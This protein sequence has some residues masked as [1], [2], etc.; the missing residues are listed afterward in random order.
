MGYRHQSVVLPI[1]ESGLTGDKNQAMIGPGALLVANNITYEHNTIRKEGGAEI[2]G[3]VPAAT[4][5]TGGHDFWPTPLIQ[6]EVVYA[7]V[8]GTASLKADDGNGSFLH[9]LA[10]GLVKIRPLFVEGGAET[11]G[12]PKKLFIFGEGLPTQVLSGT[13]LTTTVIGGTPLVPPGMLFPLLLPTNSGGGSGNVDDGGHIYVVTFVTAGGETTQGPPSNPIIIAN[14]TVNGVVK[15]QGIP[16][17][18]ANVTGRKIYRT[19]ANATTF[20][21]LMTINNNNTDEAFDNMADASLPATQPPVL[22]TTNGKPVEWT[23]TNWATCADLHERRV[24]A[25]GTPS[26]PHR[27]FYSTAEDHEN[28]MSQGAGSLSVYPGEGEKI[29]SVRSFN[30]LLVVWKYPKGIYLVDSRSADVADWTV[31]RN[32]TAWGGVSPNGEAVVDNDIVFIDPTGEIQLMSAVQEFGDLGG[33]SLSQAMQLNPLIEEQIDLSLLAHTQMVY[34][35]AKRQLHLALTA[36]GASVN[37]RRLVF[38]NNRPQQPRARLSD[39]DRPLSLWLRRDTAHQQRLMMGDD[40]GRVWT[41]DTEARTQ[42]GQGYLGHFLTNHMDLSFA[43]PGLAAKR[44][45]GEFL[46]LTIEGKG[47]QELM[48]TWYWD[49]MPSGT[50][51]YVMGPAN[52]PSLLP[53]RHRIHG[54]GYTFALE[55]I[56]SGPGEDFSIARAVLSFAVGDERIARPLRNDTFLRT[57][58]VMLVDANGGLWYAWMDR[59]G[60]LALRAVDDGPPGGT[61]LNA[62]IWYWLRRVSPDLTPWYISPDHVLPGCFLVSTVQPLGV[63]GGEVEGLVFTAPDGRIWTLDA[64][65]AGEIEL[66]EG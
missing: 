21:L 26:D 14:K 55:G 6:H 37:N 12:K 31:V 29:I 48:V 30:G 60:E 51:C 38:D 15:L 3:T 46:T 8:N 1:G 59:T 42:N 22:N 39:R 61:R 56:N 9:T 43:D 41:L 23:G 50:Y 40:V 25:G 24:W 7:W 32:G 45:L 27:L 65:N 17:G 66:I 54:S 11:G 28:F 5:I 10:T 47:P 53:V 62:E 49:G 16:I 35:A 36:K 52:H 33:T 13:A 2:Y 34:H 18:G 57:S 63:G 58:Y 44:K 64:S 20:F 4:L 19:K